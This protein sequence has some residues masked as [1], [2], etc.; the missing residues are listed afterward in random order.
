MAVALREAEKANACILDTATK[1]L[2]QARAVDE[3]KEIRDRAMAIAAYARQA[4][5]RQLEADAA[6][7]VWFHSRSARWL[8]AGGPGLKGPRGSAKYPG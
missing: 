4:K 1:A 7:C 2:A 5:N 6:E 8:T 3:V